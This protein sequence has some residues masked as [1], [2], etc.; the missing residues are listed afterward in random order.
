MPQVRF[1]SGS[2][3]TLQSDGTIPSNSSDETGV[4][5]LAGPTF[6]RRPGRH[7]LLQVTCRWSSR[8]LPP[9]QNF[10]RG[11]V[12]T[13]GPLANDRRTCATRGQTP[14]ATRPISFPGQAP[15]VNKYLQGS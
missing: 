14:G 2:L 1:E 15:L 9:S 13:A 6:R 7:P 12:C 5:I 10:S 11:S 4:C 8:R 3:G